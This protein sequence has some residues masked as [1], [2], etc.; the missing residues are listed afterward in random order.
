MGGYRRE[1]PTE[2][3]KRSSSR[4]AAALLRGRGD[5]RPVKTEQLP[6]LTAVRFVLAL[7]VILHH[8]TGAAAAPGLLPHPVYA[9]IRGGY[10]AVT[11]FF[12]LS[13]FV[14][15]GSYG[16]QEWNSER[17]RRYAAGRFARIYPVY[18]LSLVLVAPFVIADRT[19]GKSAYLAAYGLLLQGWTGH[20]PVGWNTPAWSLSCEVFFYAC[21]PLA[22]AMLRR[23]NP[24]ALA[25]VACV[26]T[27]ALFLVGVRD[28]WKPLVHL[29]DFVMGIAASGMY[30]RLRGRMAGH[31]LY[32]PSAALGVALI[33]WPQVLPSGLDL[34]TAL[35]PL[36]AA[37]LVGLALGA[38]AL[39]A[40]WAVYLGKSSYAMYILHVPV[41]WWVRRWWPHMPAGVYVTLVILISAAVYRYFEEPANRYLRGA[42]PRRASPA[43]IS[44]STASP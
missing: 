23:V 8:L 4:S 35:R 9:L 24:A 40:P 17:L 15:A 16:A 12:V 33:V 7:W 22:V 37:L 21:F 11:T 34:N 28:E 14:L 38:P 2:R 1:L 10:L 42:R 36:N 29:A 5:T 13:G 19:P 25:V 6:A 30:L 41:L 18:A 39:S 27:R 44:Y 26:L 43:Q 3:W 20:L 31:W 32:I